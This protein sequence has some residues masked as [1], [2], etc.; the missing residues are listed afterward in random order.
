MANATLREQDFQDLRIFRIRRLNIF[1]SDMANATLRE[2]DFQDLRIFRIKKL[3]IFLSESG[4]PGFKD[5]Q[6]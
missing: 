1:L 6:D 5:L 2:Q 4:F 3:D